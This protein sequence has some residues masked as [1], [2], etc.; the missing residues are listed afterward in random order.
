MI[1]S[2][3][4]GD[5]ITLGTVTAGTV[6]LDNFTGTYT[7]SGGSLDQSGG[8][9][10][11]TTAGNVTI[12]SLVGGAGGLTKKDAGT[13]T[14]SGANTFSGQLTVEN[15]TLAIAS[16]N[17]VSAN[18]TLGNSALPVILGSSGNTGTL[19]Y[20]GGTATS[21]KPLTLAAGGTGAVE[22]TNTLTLSSQIDGGGALVKTGAGT[23]TLSGTNTF[24][25]GLTVN[26]GT[27][28]ASSDAN[29]GNSAGG[30][31]FNGTC[32]FGNDGSWT[33]GSG[34]TITVSA[35]ANVT[36]NFGGASVRGPGDRQ[37][38]FHRRQTIPRQSRPEPDQ[39]RQHLHRRDES[40]R[41]RA[42]VAMPPTHSTAW[43]TMRAP[44]S[45]RWVTA[46]AKAP[47]FIWGS[48]AIAPLVLNYRQFDF[49]ARLHY[50]EQQHRLLPRQH[51][52]HQH[53]HAGYRR[54]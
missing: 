8:V 48:G 28:V 26:A 29:L 25:G 2:G 17:N 51:H 27:L 10:I 34:R 5:T 12:S 19:K 14:L 33:I 46:A 53:R 43:E 32:T 41:I 31:T 4:A 21:T 42:R 30:L 38:H 3:G 22:V 47:I 7:L 9:T 24:S 52:H 37:R 39:H 40:H 35:G 44:A 1:G 15:G 13:L 23:L 36:F 18:G 54:G 50:Q 49:G 16:I 6:L 20:T 11:G 45:S